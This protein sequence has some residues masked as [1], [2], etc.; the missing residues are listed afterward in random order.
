MKLRSGTNIYFQI[1]RGRAG[2]AANRREIARILWE[3]WSP[4]WDFD[5]ATSSAR[6]VRT[7]TQTMSTS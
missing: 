3:Q 2:L 5:D 6:R 1:E 4:D 7:T